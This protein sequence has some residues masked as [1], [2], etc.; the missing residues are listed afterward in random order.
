MSSNFRGVKAILTHW[1][2]FVSIIQLTTLLSTAQHSLD[3]LRTAAEVRNLPQEEANK[4]YP[5]L[6]QGVITYCSNRLIT[7][8][9]VQDDTEGVYIHSTKELPE[10]G[11]LVIVRGKTVQQGF[12]PNID[13]GASVEVLGTSPYP[14]PSPRPPFFLMKGKEDSKWVEVSGMVHAAYIDSSRAFEGLYLHL[15]TTNNDRITLLIK[16]QHIPPRIIG[17]FVSVQGVAGGTFN[18]ENQLTGIILFVPDMELLTIH[19]PGIDAPFEELPTLPISE[20]L[21]FKF[22][23]QEG[24]YVKVKGVVTF[25]HP[26]GR[27]AIRDSSGSLMV[28]A[29]SEAPSALSVKDSVEA[30][31]FPYIGMV[32]PLLEDATFINHGPAQ[33]SFQPSLTTLDSLQTAR[34]LDLLAITA[35]LGETIHVNNTSVLI[36]ESDNYRFEATFNTPH[37]LPS[38]PP[39]SILHLKGIMELQFNPRNNSPPAN[40]PFILHL[41]SLNDIEVIQRGPWW[42]MAHTSYLIIGFA[43][44]VGIA[45]AW[46]IILRRRILNQTR[47]IRDQLNQVQKLKV[48]AEVANKA[49]SAFLASMSHEIRTPL[50]GVIGFSSLLQDT[51]LDN[52]QKEYVSTIHSSGDMLLS[53]LDDILDFSKIEA[54]KL[55]LE[56]QPVE[57][58]RCVE[59]ALDVVLH[60]SIEK[61]LELTHFIDSSTPEWILGDSTRLR[62]II[63][64]LLSNAIKFTDEGEVSLQVYGGEISGS[65]EQ[66]VIFSVKDTG[67]GIPPSK[68]SSIFDIFTQADS[69]TTRKF[70]G[71]GLGLAICKRLSQL[72]GGDIW[73]ESIEEHGSKFSF[74]IK[75]ERIEAQ[76]PDKSHEKSTQFSGRTA[77]IV[78][79]NQ[80]TRKL[81]ITYCQQWGMNYIIASDGPESL[82]KSTY[83]PPFDIA[84]INFSLASN[85]GLNVAKTI[86]ERY[87]NTPIVIVR[88]LN[89]RMPTTNPGMHVL[90]LPVK[91]DTLYN[92]LLSIFYSSNGKRHTSKLLVEK[93]E[94]NSYCVGLVENNRIYR[95]ILH[96]LLIQ[97]GYS[98]FAFAELSELLDELESNSFNAIML[99]IDTEGS[100]DSLSK[101]ISHI[102]TTSPTSSIITMSSQEYS[103][104]MTES[105]KNQVA[106]NLKKPIP[107]QDLTQVFSSLTHQFTN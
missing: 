28:Q 25:I 69:S 24:H 14:D 71:T 45:F 98:V 9:F 18:L 35:E 100:L 73:V 96:R 10:D 19:T 22:N 90:H 54:G 15:K 51:T 13:F 46:S 55:T 97:Q 86:Q 41:Q 37:S 48:E 83:I 39:G 63:I 70:G 58:H 2:V 64:N 72:M 53:V 52:E 60:K 5:V 78:E 94:N 49:K 75:S 40:R 89:H 62:Q 106:A 11:S 59:E 6:I 43:M 103:N 81:L 31:G 56:K 34:N 85:N 7:S 33:R 29:S 101:T 36:L 82:D 12:A 3:T 1:L 67:I 57:L 105:V 23:P 95:K 76:N 27:F 26:D 91:Q 50:N 107:L 92:L 16:T 8:C 30:A 68:V 32:S 79:T 102:K 87:V 21:S 20:V 77:F 84:F 42:T 38:Y 44:V 99:D 61:N 104:D 47:T 80:T 74:S 4:G 66:I 93:E 88:S 17:S 65:N